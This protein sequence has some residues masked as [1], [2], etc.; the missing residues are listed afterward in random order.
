MRILSY[1]HVWKQAWLRVW[2]QKRSNEKKL[3]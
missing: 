2:K 1:R 3:S